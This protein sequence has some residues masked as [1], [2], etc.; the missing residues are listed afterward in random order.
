MRAA[1][2]AFII[3]NATLPAHAAEEFISSAFR[4]V[5]PDEWRLTRGLPSIPA[6]APL[7]RPDCEYDLRNYEADD[8]LISI[9][10]E[11]NS[12]YDTESGNWGPITPLAAFHESVTDWKD[13]GKRKELQKISVREFSVRPPL[14][15]MMILDGWSRLLKKQAVRLI[16][17]R[18]EGFVKIEIVGPKS[19]QKTTALLSIFTDSFAKS[20]EEQDIPKCHF[21]GDGGPA[22]WRTWKNAPQ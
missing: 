11:A 18:D 3:F 15:R 1:L 21:K 6:L 9:S 17:V 8:M 10:W 16:A 13:R 19:S 22:L 20:V 4:I 2:V 12:V 14:R 5:L 7:Q